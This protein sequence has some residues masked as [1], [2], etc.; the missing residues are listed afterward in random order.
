MLED[1]KAQIIK[2]AGEALER[3]DRE[4]YERLKR[5]YPVDAG[6]IMGLKRIF[7]G[8]EVKKMNY[9]FSEV[10]QKHGVNWHSSKTL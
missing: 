3:G 10:E 5:Q 2:A 8:E 9:N 7:G 4:T 1:Q 6:F